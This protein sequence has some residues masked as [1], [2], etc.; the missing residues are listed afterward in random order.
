[1]EAH[2]EIFIDEFVQLKYEQ[3]GLDSEGLRQ[4]TEMDMLDLILSAIMSSTTFF[5]F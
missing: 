5:F 4:W 1:M 3:R 2:I